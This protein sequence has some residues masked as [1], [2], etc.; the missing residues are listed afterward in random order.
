MKTNTELLIIYMVYYIFLVVR[1]FTGLKS[2]KNE[3]F[4]AYSIVF[5]T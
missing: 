3:K 2:Y 1:T 5:V 4:Y